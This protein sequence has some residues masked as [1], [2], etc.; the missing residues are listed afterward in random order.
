MGLIDDGFVHPRSE[1][2]LSR[3]DPDRLAVDRTPERSSF[4]RY[5]QAHGDLRGV[6]DRLCF[7]RAQISP[8]S[9]VSALLCHPVKTAKSP[10]LLRGFLVSAATILGQRMGRASSRNPSTEPRGGDGF[11][12]NSTHPTRPTQ[13][14]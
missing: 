14:R 6:S 10:G 8:D 7:A 11:R 12:K 5:C 13:Y 4:N 1:D 3:S 2:R 9:Y